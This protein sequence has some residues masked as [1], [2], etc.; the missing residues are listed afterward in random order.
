MQLLLIFFMADILA[1]EVFFRPP[2]YTVIQEVHGLIPGARDYSL[3]GVSAAWTAAF[4]ITMLKVPNRLIRCFFVV[5]AVLVGLSGPI[6]GDNW[7]SDILAS[8]VMG[9]MAC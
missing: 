3:P 1:S 2:P 7:P 8:F 6:G 5:I 9:G 4:A